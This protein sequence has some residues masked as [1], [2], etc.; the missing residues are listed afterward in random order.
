[1]QVTI[2]TRAMQQDWAGGLPSQAVRYMLP[3][4]L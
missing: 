4:G 1:V 2:V 3:F